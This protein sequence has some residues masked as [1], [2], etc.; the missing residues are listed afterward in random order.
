MPWLFANAMD[1]DGTP[2][3]ARSSSPAAICASSTSAVACPLCFWSHSSDALALGSS[4]ENNCLSAAPLS[5]RAP[6]AL[7]AL[8]LPAA[9]PCLSACSAAALEKS[10][11][12]TTPALLP[13]ISAAA[14]GDLCTIQLFNASR[15]AERPPVLLLLISAAACG[16][17]REPLVQCS[18]NRCAE[19][20]VQ[21]VIGLVSQGSFCSLLT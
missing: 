11:P 18:A 6:A 3:P 9:P 20:Q 19:L 8:L 2:S 16:D 15:A 13:L 10:V 21:L 1:L 5:G 17:L 14:F 7:P 4:A 12:A